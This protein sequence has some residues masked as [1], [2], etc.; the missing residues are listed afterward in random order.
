MM[1]PGLLDVGIQYNITNPTILSLTLSIFL[2]SFAIGPL[3]MAPF[4]EMYG[5]VWVRGAL[6]RSLLPRSP[7]LLQGAPLVE[8]SLPRVQYRLC[9]STKYRNFYCLPVSR[10]AIFCQSHT[11]R[12]PFA[13]PDLQ[14]VHQ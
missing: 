10:C 1:A 8:P 12:L 2:L 5:R 13:K 7:Q 9:I 11:F 14:E 4:S 3:F 6:L